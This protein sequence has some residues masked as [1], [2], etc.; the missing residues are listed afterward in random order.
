MGAFRR[1]VE[2]GVDR[3]L[4]DDDDDSNR[5]LHETV[6]RRGSTVEHI[7]V[8]FSC[9]NRVENRRK[10][11]VSRRMNLKR[12]ILSLSCTEMKAKEG[13]VENRCTTSGEVTLD[14][15]S[16]SAVCP[17][18]EKRER[19][20]PAELCGEQCR[21]SETRIRRVHTFLPLLLSSSSAAAFSSSCSAGQ[22]G[23][24]GGGGRRERRRKVDC[25]THSCNPCLIVAI[26]IVMFIIMEREKQ[27]RQGRGSDSQSERE[28]EQKFFL[29]FFM[30]IKSVE[31]ISFSLVRS[32]V[33]LLLLSSP[34]RRS[35]ENCAEHRARKSSIVRVALPSSLDAL[36]FSTFAILSLS[37]RRRRRMKGK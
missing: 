9:T 10:K 6:A 33:R 28:R 2:A 13:H 12:E 27:N 31:R 20:E 21:D 36:S 15:F 32:F 29:D 16:L 19:E 18:I 17:T 37:N 11:G 3:S 34:R 35:K 4:A 22:K 7:H 14:A 23:G 25:F 30:N 8:I 24:G 26:M 5:C 1:Q